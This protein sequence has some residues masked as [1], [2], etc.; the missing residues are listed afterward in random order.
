MQDR[1]PQ[2][3]DEHI[4]TAIA[5]WTE[6]RAKLADLQ[7]ASAAS[8]AGSKL[9]SS[10]QAA[11][12]LQPVADQQ[13]I[14]ARLW[15]EVAQVAEVRALATGDKFPVRTKTCVA[16]DDR[17]SGEDVT[18]MPDTLVNILIVDDEPGNLMVLEAVLD[19][20]SYRLVRAATGEEALLAMMADDFACYVLDVRM[21]GMT[22]FELARISKQ[23]RKSAAVPIIFLTAHFSEDQ[24]VVEGYESGAV[25]Y[26][27]KPVNPAMLRS[28]IAVFSRLHKRRREAEHANRQLR[29]EVAE[30]RRAEALLSGL[31]SSLDQ[32]VTERTMQLEQSNRQKDGFLATLAHELRNPL[33]PVRSAVEV[34]KLKAQPSADVQ[35]C[36]TIIDRQVTRMARLIDDL[37]DISRVNAGRVEMRP[38]PVE[39]AAVVTEAI[40]AVQPQIDHH[41]LT[42]TVEM[43]STPLMVTGDPTRLAQVFMNLLGNAANYTKQGGLIEVRAAMDGDTVMVSITD[44]GVGIGAERLEQVFEMFSQEVPVLS[45]PTNGGLGIGLALTRQLVQMHGGTVTAHSEGVGKGSQFVVKL[46]AT[47]P[48]QIVRFAE[49]PTEANPPP[50]SVRI[51]VVDD[52]RDAADTLK[53]ILELAGHQACVVYEADAAVEAAASFDAELVLLDIGMPKMNGYEVCAALRAE[54]HGQSRMVVAVSGWGQADDMQKSKDAG[55][56]AHLVK[57]VGVEELV[58]LISKTS[59]AKRTTYKSSHLNADEQEDG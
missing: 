30:R 29:A 10:S 58:K 27:Q 35:S 45:R 51:L 47:G 17:G 37:M 56:D 44:N 54:E 52:N 16:K 8:S 50:G 20:P 18:P 41:G 26:L 59:A 19:D 21:P 36:V 24:N 1:I 7:S 48:D 28:K 9:S 46:P 38:E 31:N 23:R 53:A 3:F 5:A 42:L 25:D 40:Q 15:A 2:D 11:S 22:G 49:P 13:A 6:A 32:R 4:A 57:P 34:L 14:C 12:Q 55:F 43:S 39:I 33:A